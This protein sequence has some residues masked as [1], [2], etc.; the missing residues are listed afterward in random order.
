[1][2]LGLKLRFASPYGFIISTVSIYLQD[3]II[4]SEKSLPERF[5]DIQPKSAY[6]F[7]SFSVS[8]PSARLGN[9]SS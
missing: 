7:L 2:E 5:H 3:K 9:H 1:M 6:F 8:P 4:A